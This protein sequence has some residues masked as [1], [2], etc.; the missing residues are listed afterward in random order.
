MGEVPPG[1]ICWDLFLV[2]V[3]KENIEMSYS[4]NPNK[5][6]CSIC[7]SK[8]EKQPDKRVYETL[9]DHI[10]NPNGVPPERDYYKCSNKNC[11]GH[12][13]GMFFDESG[14]WYSHYSGWEDLKPLFK[15]DCGD[16]LESP[17]RSATMHIYHHTKLINTKYFKLQV[18][19]YRFKDIPVWP[20]KLEFRTFK[21]DD[22]GVRCLYDKHFQILGNPVLAFRLWWYRFE[23]FIG[24]NK[25]VGN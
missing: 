1:K 15:N 24:L 9:A 22:T 16:A 7:K 3:S 18:E 2:F 20:Y 11:A 4:L 12:K 14:S 5:W 13:H 6:S 8:L 19:W 25:K 23:I 17:S 21:K 10:S